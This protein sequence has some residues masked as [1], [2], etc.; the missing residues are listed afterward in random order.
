MFQNLLFLLI[1]SVLVHNLRDSH[2]IG[3]DLEWEFISEVWEYERKP[4]PE[5][6]YDHESKVGVI[7]EQCGT[8]NLS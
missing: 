7:R 4:V 2:E 6:L 8:G 3:A 5:T 1:F